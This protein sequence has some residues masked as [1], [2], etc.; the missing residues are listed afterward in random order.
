MTVAP[1]RPEQEQEPIDP[2]IRARRV[3][4]V[5]EQGQRRLRL[6]LFVVAFLG[7]LGLAWLAIESAAL[8]VDHIEVHGSGGVPVAEVVAA[9]GIRRGDALTFVDTGAARERVDAL[10][11]IAS[12]KVSRSFP[13]TVTIQV[14]EREPAAW[15]SL[16]VRKGAPPGPVVFLD[17]QGRVIEEGK[18]PAVGLPEIRGLGRL[19]DVGKR[20]RPSGAVTLLRSLPAA[21]R[22]QVATVTIEHGEA[23]L[24][25]R[26][27]AGGWPSAGSVR[28][29]AITDVRAKG[30]AALA[31]LG[32]LEES[33]GYLDV[34]VP[35]APATGG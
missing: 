17:A 28:L 6:I 2:R 20:V 18:S 8:D 19:P 33:V 21:L 11:R 1:P 26:E 30:I 14:T 29:G 22:S 31:V 35:S 15:V 9:S 25:L 3:A 34:R 12:A 10:P 7:V 5:R 24:G 13:G 4:V 16:P 27:R 23:S 32:G